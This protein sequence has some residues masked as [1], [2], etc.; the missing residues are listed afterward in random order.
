MSEQPSFTTAYGQRVVRVFVSSTFRDMRVERDYLVKFIFPQLR[1]LCEARG[2]TWG[3]V[4][5]RWGITEQESE[6]GE[7]LRLCLEEIDRCRP[8]FIGLLGDYYGTLAKQVASNLEPKDGWPENCA[9]LSVT[10]LEIL[11]GVLAHPQVADRAFFYFRDPAYTLSLPPEQQRAFTNPD[12]TA[13]AKLAELKERIR[14]RHRG[15]LLKYPPRENYAN[16]EALGE[17]VLEDFTRLINELFPEDQKPGPLDREAADHDAFAQS[18]AW[19]Y[20]GRQEYFDCLDEHVSSPATAGPLVVLGESGIGKSALLANWFLEYRK[21]HPDDFALIHFIG[22]TPDSL[23]PVRLLQRIMWELKRRFPNQLPDD[24]PEKIHEEFPQWLARAAASGKIILILDGLNQFEDR[25]AAPDLGWLPVAFPPNCRVILSTLPGRSLDATRHRQ[26]PEMTVQPL[27]VPER[28]E[29]LEKFLAQYSRRLSPARVE[30]IAS[31][32]QTAN[33]LFLRAMLDE[34]RQFGE[35]ERLSERIK[36]YLAAYDPK[37]LYERILERW[38]QDYGQNLVRQS[39]SLIW[40]ARR[41]L[42][43]AELLD[44]LG[45]DGQP[46]PRANWTPLFLAVASSLVSH[47]GYVGFAHDYIRKA[48]HRRYLRD[49]QQSRATRLCIARYFG[50]RELDFRKVEEFPWQLWRARQWSD[51]YQFLAGADTFTAVAAAELEDAK[52]Y[53]VGME[54]NSDLRLTTAYGNVI[55]SP[56]GCSARFLDIL[57]RV[58]HAIGHDVEASGISQFMARNVAQLPKIEDRLH[59]LHEDAKSLYRTGHPREALAAHQEVESLARENGRLDSVASSLNEQA[60]ILKQF[61]RLD[62]ALDAHRRQR[63]ILQSLGDG[64][65]VLRSLFNQA[66]VLGFMG[67]GDEAEPI[68]EHC[69]AEARRLRQWDFVACCLQELSLY[70]L[71]RNELDVAEQLLAEKESICLQH[72]LRRALATCYSTQATI[73]SH[74]QDYD[75]ALHLL[76]RKEEL[77]IKTGDNLELALTWANQALILACDR[78]NCRRALKLIDKACDLAEHSGYTLYVQKLRDQQESIRRLCRGL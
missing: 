30:R 68:V 73:R 67:K 16:P 51:L 18:R 66:I 69:L 11:H 60:N 10:E 50:S 57:M 20:I 72:S 34:L 25:D 6:R 46:L 49:D 29:L 27:T 39:L 22:G 41:G 21:N 28:K 45:E 52:M 70:R 74:R 38:E 76:E 9:E 15:E 35:H 42:S 54:A 47:S 65:G 40:A 64:L 1:K 78:R 7:V 55:R 71:D 3:E 53:W 24:I 8:Y 43:E 17:L 61:N 37:E 77:C 62:E 33:P 2:V 31:A 58:L 36:H 48:I 63:E 19:V 13:K 44:L 5:L 4:D 75:G 32:E 23:D 12:L 14:Q 59:I 56:S 26:W